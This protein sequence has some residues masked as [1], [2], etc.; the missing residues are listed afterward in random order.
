MGGT[1]TRH[2]LC[3]GSREKLVNE[4]EEDD[5]SDTYNVVIWDKKPRAGWKL[6][7]K[8]TRVFDLL[9]EDD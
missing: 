4:E 1:I 7:T 9:S 5:D 6:I 2:C 3:L 8:R